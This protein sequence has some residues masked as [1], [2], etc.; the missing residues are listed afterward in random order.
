MD[1]I[2]RR[3]GGE[4]VVGRPQ[5]RPHWYPAATAPAAR[6][7]VWKRNADEPAAAA[8]LVGVFEPGQDY[9]VDFNPLTDINVLLG[10]NPLSAA[11]TP[12]FSR[13]EDFIWAE[14]LV[15][16]DRATVAGLDENVPTVT[17]P[18]VVSKVSAEELL[19]LIPAPANSSTWIDGKIRVRRADTLAEVVIWD[20]LAG[21]QHRIT[22]PAMACVI[23]YN[24]RNQS[25]ENIG[26]GRG[27]SDWSPTAPA[28]G[29]GDADQPPPASEAMND[30]DFDP[31]DHRAG[32]VRGVIAE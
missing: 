29:I 10:L 6:A 28:A 24:C 14:V 31:A 15:S 22:Q 9:R 26:N 21:P 25:E 13:P 5:A 23:D 4:S 2:A 7:Q 11:G 30:F 27:V 19:I 16:R 3:S 20:V 12:C 1:I 18:P 17:G 32:I 8:V